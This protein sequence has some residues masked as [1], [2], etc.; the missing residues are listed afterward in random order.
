MAQE[1]D[2]NEQEN[3]MAEVT[4]ALPRLDEDVIATS[5]DSVTTDTPDTTEAVASA[6]STKPE[7]DASASSTKPS[8]EESKPD[9]HTL[10]TIGDT[11]NLADVATALEA[12]IIDTDGIASG[13]ESAEPSQPAP[14]PA[15]TSGDTGRHLS[16]EE[17]KKNPRRILIPILIVLAV[18]A[19]AYGAGVFYFSNHFAPNTRV[20]GIDAS[21]L[22]VEQLAERAEAAAADYH[23][24]VEGDGISFDLSTADLGLKVDGTSLAQAAFAEQTN[25]A[26]PVTLVQGATLEPEIPT[27]IDDAKLRAA[28]ASQVEAFNATAK[29]PTNAR[30]VYNEEQGAFEVTPMEAGTRLSAEAVAN[31]V[32]TDATLLKATTKIGE[33]ELEPPTYF[34]D[35]T[36]LEAACAKANEILACKLQLKNDD[37]N[38]VAIDKSL[39]SPWIDIL[40]EDDLKAIDEQIAEKANAEEPEKIEYENGEYDYNGETAEWEWVWYEPTNPWDEYDTDKGIQFTGE[41]GEHV[42]VRLSQKKIREWGFITLNDLVNGEDEVHTWEVDSWA[43]AGLIK[44]ALTQCK[45]GDIQVATVIVD[46][47]PPE[48]EGHEERGRHIDVNLSTQYARLYDDDGKTVLWRSYIVSGDPSH[49]TVT[50]EFSLDWKDTNIIMVGADEDGDGEPDYRTPCTYWMGFYLNSYGIHD[51][52]WRSYYGGDIHSWYGSHGCVNVSLEKAEELYNLSRLG[53]PVYVHY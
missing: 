29:A 51:A 9:M 18:L 19:V 52:Y 25:T 12:P 32:A 20:G 35:S 6:S 33:T 45:S 38:I 10:P 21:G 40:Y 4:Q 53:D 14:S 36:A 31:R 47:R 16:L 34:T 44:D 3:E 15:P 17:A 24:T 37:K 43:T 8:D 50:G 23:L 46:E 28:V 22:T 5:D 11:D 1:L 42:N 48:T 39:I 41:N 27:T 2:K 13:E 7:G 49:P 30:V 26:W